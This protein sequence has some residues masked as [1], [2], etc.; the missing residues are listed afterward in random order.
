MI[1]SLIQNLCKLEETFA[2][3]LISMF[4]VN[5]EDKCFINGWQGQL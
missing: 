3:T 2:V 1:T 5:E 4:F